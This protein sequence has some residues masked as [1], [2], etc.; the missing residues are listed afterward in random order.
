LTDAPQIPQIPKRIFPLAT[1]M[2]E[3]ELD[4]SAFLSDIDG[5]RST[6]PV[7][8]ASKAARRGEKQ[9]IHHGK[10]GWNAAANNQDG[11]P[12]E[13]DPEDEV[14][15]EGDWMDMGTVNL[16]ML[17]K[18][19]VLVEGDLINSDQ[20]K[21]VLLEIGRELCKKTK[22]RGMDKY[23]KTLTD[24]KSLAVQ[25]EGLGLFVPGG[26]FFADGVWLKDFH[27]FARREEKTL[28]H[29]EE[30]DFTAEGTRFAKKFRAKADG[31]FPGYLVQRE[32]AALKSAPK[33]EGPDLQAMH[34]EKL[35]VAS[36]EAFAKAPFLQRA[37]QTSAKKT[38]LL[39]NQFAPAKLGDDLIEHA[40]R[41][42]DFFCG[43]SH[44]H[45]TKDNFLPAVEMLK[46]LRTSEDP[47][48]DAEVAKASQAALVVVA[49][50]LVA[51]EAAK[52]ENKYN[53]WN[54]ITASRKGT[55]ARL[56]IGTEPD[57]KVRGEKLQKLSHN[58]VCLLFTAHLDALLPAPN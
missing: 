30:A 55:I 42:A 14:L 31:H 53:P 39:Q 13:G 15:E 45:L 49:I 43:I 56:C 4:P 5:I 54:A 18:L 24:I 11:G 40:M 52:T 57:E 10:T 19:I 17:D 51:A 35:L 36:A 50:G 9:M 23:D 46:N 25:G 33:H 16:E 26:P 34:L 8:T 28:P 58:E 22:C 21:E 3:S 2:P 20:S 41:A 7:G 1:K 44:P 32:A 47:A 37:N 12:S 38:N 48:T 27:K 6:A 29:T